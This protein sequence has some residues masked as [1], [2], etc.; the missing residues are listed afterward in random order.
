MK[1]KYLLPVAA[2]FVVAC[3]EPT[4]PVSDLGISAGKHTQ[5]PP[6][7]SGPVET[8]E[9]GVASL[10]SWSFNG[11]T[12]SPGSSKMAP[13]GF[14]GRLLNQ[15]VSLSI[16]EGMTSVT[17]SFD[18]YIIGTWDGAGQQGF[19]GDWW[20]IEVSRNGGARENLFHTSFSNQATKPQHFPKQ[21]TDGTSPA[22]KGAYATNWLG[23]PKASGK[24]DVGDAIYK[25]SY[26]ISNPG[27][28]PLVLYFHTTTSL[29]DLNDESWGL[30]NVMV[31]GN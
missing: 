5:P 24:F 1:A 21:V 14:L 2:V 12:T 17:V 26:T 13:T 3:S 16:P 27:A 8:F 19:G 23:F 29:Q 6:A 7:P 20:Q 28:G 25:L 15:E 18:L 11:L 10:S 9:N 4:S 22:D 31:A 30:D